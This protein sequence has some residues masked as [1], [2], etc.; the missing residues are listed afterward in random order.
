MD[1]LPDKDCLGKPCVTPDCK[2]A[3]N[4]PSV[5]YKIEII[6]SDGNIKSQCMQDPAAENKQ[7]E[8]AIRKRQRLK[9]DEHKTD[10][11]P[12]KTKTRVKKINAPDRSQSSDNIAASM[13]PPSHKENKPLQTGGVSS[14]KSDIPEKNKEPKLMEMN[15]TAAQKDFICTYFLMLLNTMGP[16]SKEKVEEEWEKFYPNCKPVSGLVSKSSGIF[17]LLKNSPYFVML[18]NLLCIK[19]SS[20]STPKEEKGVTV[21]SIVTNTAIEESQPNLTKENIQLDSEIREIEKELSSNNVHVN[22]MNYNP[23]IPNMVPRSQL[24]NIQK[25]IFMMEE[26]KPKIMMNPMNP[27]SLKNYSLGRPTSL[28]FFEDLKSDDKRYTVPIRETN[29]M[30]E[31]VYNKSMETNMVQEPMPITYE[32]Y[33]PLPPPIQWRDEGIESSIGFSFGDVDS[34]FKNMAIRPPRMKDVQST[35]ETRNRNK[36]MSTQTEETGENKHS[37]DDESWMQHMQMA[38]NEL[39]K[40]N[41]DLMKI[42]HDMMRDHENE[43]EALRNQIQTLRNSYED[44]IKS[45]K[46]SVNRNVD[47][48]RRKMIALEQRMKIHEQILQS[49]KEEL[50]KKDFDLLEAKRNLGTA[51]L[52][53]I[54]RESN[55]QVQRLV[56]ALASLPCNNKDAD[57]VGRAMAKWEV[58]G[59]QALKAKIEFWTACTT[60]QTKLYNGFG[61]DSLQELIIP[62]IEEPAG[63]CP[64]DNLTIILLQDKENSE[65]NLPKPPTNAPPELPPFRNRTQSQPVPPVVPSQSLPPPP[66]VPIP[67]TTSPIVAPLSP[68]SLGARP[69]EPLPSTNGESA[70]RSWPSIPSIQNSTHSS[71]AGTARALSNFGK[72]MTELRRCYPSRSEDELCSAVKAVRR[73]NKYSL[74]GLTIE[75]IVTMVGT[76]LEWWPEP[77]EGSMGLDKFMGWASDVVAPKD[78][79]FSSVSKVSSEWTMNSS[80]SV[81]EGEK[82]DCCICLQGMSEPK[83]ELICLHSF[84]TKCIRQWLSKESVCPICRKFTRM[85]DEFPTLK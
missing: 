3:F 15:S 69:R 53:R 35:Y 74:S 16:L 48:D 49:T 43:V 2:N 25:E 45:L 7:K 12:T 81:H 6:G 1:K 18:D 19:E 71:S 78:E 29:K 40:K 63:P 68:T 64:L 85:P 31:Y 59:N 33:L 42:R 60:H 26:E 51:M 11:L 77:T 34:A 70:L 36:E 46:E 38:V 58:T 65:A 28:G 55:R 83:T 5:I 17:N 41:K 56:T 22:S 75:R 62:V 8:I 23:V 21:N 14:V 47:D 20:E 44:Y 82:E 57:A 72:L 66:N 79:T 9:S 27:I 32:E 50:R 80:N 84:H 52:E 30:N 37:N 54:E 39:I 76:A 13:K 10:K 24:E 4:E 67:V 73:K 61:S